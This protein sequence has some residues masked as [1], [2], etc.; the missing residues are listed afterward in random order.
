MLGVLYALAEHDI[1]RLLAYHSIENIGII[2]MGVGSSMIFS[3][4]GMNQFVSLA[5][6]A[7]LFHTMNHAVFK[8][9][10]FLG[11]GSVI[12][13]THTR[14]MEEY[15]GLI[16]TMP[17]TALF[18]LIGAIA[19]SGLPPFNGFASEWLTY[20][21]LFAGIGLQS[22]G[23]Q[24]VFIVAISSLAFTGGL[25]AACFVK[26]F[27]TT[28]LARPRSTEAE[29]AHEAETSAI[30][31]MGTLAVLCLVL[32]LGS[33]FIT[34]HLTSVAQT[35]ALVADTKNSLLTTAGGIHIGTNTTVLNLPLVFAGVL[36]A[37]MAAFGFA[38]A[39]SRQQKTVK[40]ITWNCG[41]EYTTGRME[42][43][44]TGFAR[45]LILIFRGIFQPSKQSTVEY[46]D[47]NTH[48]PYLTKSKKIMLST[49]N[50]YEKYM[51]LPVDSYAKR[52]SEKVALSQNGVINTYLL[53]IFITLIGLLIWVRYS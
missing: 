7:A 47:A 31:S 28:F 12:A 5:L 43:T 11:A 30:V 29:K 27:G 6:A 46:V 35:L 16:K 2:L 49:L 37:G 9:L 40:D 15:G 4:L 53:Y 22:A 51:Y 24:S 36:I 48:N 8:S 20:Q 50:V 17:Y 10:L 38:Y 25:A 33:A 14:N 45:S 42:I 23:V 18:F 34:A 1:K 26:A 3:T 13:K 41:F 21:S 44:S 19:I 32:G 39:T 52:I